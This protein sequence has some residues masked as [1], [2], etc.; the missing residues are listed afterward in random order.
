MAWRLHPGRSVAPIAALVLVLLVPALAAAHADLV[1]AIPADGASVGGPVTFISGQ[2]SEDLASG[3]SLKV[4]DAN[5]ATVATGSIDPDSDRR[6]VA[7][8]D[9]PL[10]DGTF[11][12]DSTAIAADG[13][14]EK[15]TWTFTVT[16]ASPEPTPVA[17]DPGSPQPTGGPTPTGTPTPS[18]T[19]TETPAPSAEPGGTSGGGEVLLPILAALAIVAVGGALLLGRGRRSGPAG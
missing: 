12:V 8:P 6:M 13:H 7:R 11:R 19:A 4:T 2:Y 1:R 17:S 3:S 15:V 10:I 9:T 14:I 16:P 18:P 5:G